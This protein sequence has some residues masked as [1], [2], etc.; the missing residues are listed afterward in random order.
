MKSVRTLTIVALTALL[1]GSLAIAQTGGDKPD[2]PKGDGP[3]GGRGPGGPGAMLDNLL[4]PRV[5]DELKLTTEQKSKYDELQAAFKKEVDAWKT[6]HPNAQEQMRKAREDGDHEAMKKLAEE[7]KPVLD[8]RKANVDK[9]RESLTTEQKAALDKAM[10]Q[11][12][13]RR[14]PGPGAPSG[15]GPG[16]GGPKGEKPPPP[17]AD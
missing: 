4:P 10:E 1:A 11:A 17:P 13:N 14:G 15:N 5:L 6:A 9:L 16:A 2:A 8:A 7:R 3:R 12:R